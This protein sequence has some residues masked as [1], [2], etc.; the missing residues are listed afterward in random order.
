MILLFT[1]ISKS[2][3]IAEIKE[4]SIMETYLPDY[5]TRLKLRELAKRDA[6]SERASFWRSI[7][8]V[9]PRPVDGHKG[10]FG[11]S[12]AVGGSRGMS[13]SISLTGGAALV[14]GS[15]LVRIFTPDAILETVAQYQREYT[16]IPGACDF[17]GRLTSSAA[18]DIFSE[19]SRATAVAVGPGL[20][21]SDELDALVVEL[22]YELEQP[23]VFDADA[24]NV[25]A[26]RG[27][28]EGRNAGERRPRGARVLTPHPGEFYRLTGKKVEKDGLQRLA[29]VADFSARCVELFEGTP[30]V[31]VLKGFQ[32]ICRDV[33]RDASFVNATGN[34]NL[35]TG[36]SGDVLTGVILGLLAQG[37]SVF[38]ASCLGVALHG[39]TA[40]L[41][42]TVLTRGMLASDAVRFLPL[43]FDYLFDVQA[44]L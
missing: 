12:L 43:A 5:Q 6:K 18:S 17:A 21:R 32:T 38:D 33:K 27:V 30:L 10:T 16:T 3:N 19:A 11:T 2:F 1:R 14:A 7:P 40:E 41:R 8:Q 15:G 22:F 31:V 25:L 26:A 36:G 34:S 42:Q 13:G 24:L 4:T 44:E 20:G 23:T 28:F 39:L 9:P 35:A 37:A 29:A